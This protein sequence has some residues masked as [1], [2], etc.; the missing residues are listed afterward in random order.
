[1]IRATTTPAASRLQLWLT[2]TWLT[3]GAAVLAAGFLQAGAHA[4]ARANFISAHGQKPLA[5][6][7]EPVPPANGIKT[8]VWQGQDVDGDGAPDFVNPTGQAPRTED[9]YGYG[10]FGASRDGGVR[11][12]E[13]VDFVAEAGQDVAAPISGYVTKI[14]A[15]YA[16]DRNLKFVE[17][18]NP[19]IGYVARV[20]YI[21]PTV[22]EGDVVRLG[23]AIGKAHGLQARYPG[24][25]TD[26]VHLELMGPDQ[27][28]MDATA[29]LTERYV[30]RFG[31]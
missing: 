29:V 6:A 21:D 9:A 2:Q 18:T 31:A 11:K 20:F 13:G 3:L 19:A 25:M 17:V 14:G 10:A 8:L 4:A 1:M 22:V 26:H 28:R 27:K 7:L 24:G 12:H 23:Q 16:D 5:L 15:A 30:T